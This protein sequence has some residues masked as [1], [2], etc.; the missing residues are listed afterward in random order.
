FP[1]DDFAESYKIYATDYVD[2]ADET[3]TSAEMAAKI[4]LSQYFWNKAE[5][6]SLDIIFEESELCAPDADRAL[7]K[8]YSCKGNIIYVTDK[9]LIPADTEHFT[10]AITTFKN[11][12]ESEI[13]S[14][15][16][17]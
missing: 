10:L 15:A 13:E 12:Q 6:N 17:R 9:T 14:W 5:I 7:G 8:A 16:W 3:G 11:S 1:E 4:L 2:I